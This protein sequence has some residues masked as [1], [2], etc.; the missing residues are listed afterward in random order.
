MSV[1]L[2]LNNMKWFEIRRQRGMAKVVSHL[3]EP[4]VGQSYPNYYAAKLAASLSK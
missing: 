2:E 4:K 1:I 3:E